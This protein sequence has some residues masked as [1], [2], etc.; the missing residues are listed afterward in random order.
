MDTLR[1]LELI[2]SDTKESFDHFLTWRVATLSDCES[3]STLVHSGYRAE[4]SHQGW[5]TEDALVGGN[6]TDPDLLADIIQS[7]DN[8]ILLFFG[9]SENILIGC[10]H[11]QYESEL[12]RAWLGMFT[13]RPDR[14]GRG[15]GKRILS[16]AE[17]YAQDT[18]HAEFMDMRVIVQRPELIAFYNRHG[19]LDTNQR[20]AFP[21]D[22]PRLGIAK[23]KG[24]EICVL[25]KGLKLSKKKTDLNT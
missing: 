20:Q 17:T 18:W 21:P 6:R 10:V 19:Y 2:Q 23:R 25:R 5:T 13:V 15:Y 4:A 1:T 14:Q 3:I 8:I 24:L 12:R 16:T 11:L 22:N 9:E 7:K